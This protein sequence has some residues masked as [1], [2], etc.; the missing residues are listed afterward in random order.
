MTVEIIHN[1]GRTMYEYKVD[2]YKIKY[3]EDAM[4]AYAKE[5]WRV[6]AVT[7]DHHHE[8]FVDVFY[9]RPAK[10]AAD[11]KP[12]E[13]ADEK[14]AA[15]EIPDGNDDDEVV[16]SEAPAAGEDD[17]SRQEIPAAEED[18]EDKDSGIW[19]FTGENESEDKA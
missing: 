10:A 11:N 4:N 5:G 17:D 13:T 16:V 8:G 2:V 3:S 7:P 6:I 18:P 1:G 15:N 9:E 14:G 19:E 12:P